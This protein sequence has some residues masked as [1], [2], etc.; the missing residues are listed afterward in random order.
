MFIT[1]KNATKRYGTKE[2]AIYALNDV[3][4][5]TEQGEIVVI[6]GASG[7]GKSTLLNMLGGL[8][9]PDSGKI[10][11]NGHH[12]E[13]MSGKQLSEYRRTDVGFIFQSYNLVPD[14][15][16]YENAELICDTADNTISV[17]TLFQELG[18]SEHKNH[19]PK[20][21]SG[22]QQQRVAIAR[23]MVKNPKLLLCDELTAALDS[24]SSK[25]VLK[26]V[27]KMNQNHG[28]T[29]LIVT[30]NELIAKM[31][32]RVIKMKDGKIIENGL[33]AEKVKAAELEM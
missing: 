16:A 13:A 7:S 8:D 15:T 14:L 27:E 30:H 32:D 11:V 17:E 3:S 12:L 21:L 10:E 24:K 29:I 20:E 22:G 33:N 25:E 26:L 28:T 2:N 5:E 6:L 4:F 23:A 1:V 18:L 9:Q 31:A 19:F